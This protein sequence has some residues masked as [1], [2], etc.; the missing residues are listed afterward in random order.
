MHPPVSRLAGALTAA[1]LAALLVFPAG[2]AATTNEPIAEVHL[3]VDLVADLAVGR[4]GHHDHLA[5]GPGRQ[6]LPEE[7]VLLRRADDVVVPDHRRPP[8]VH[9]TVAPGGRRDKSHRPRLGV[10]A[11][12]RATRRPPRTEPDCAFA[13][14]TGTF[15]PAAPSRRRQG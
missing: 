15:S 6:D 5:V 3:G 10:P 12:K 4:D 14:A 7:A 8:S 13:A 9:E 11:R 2:A 1:S